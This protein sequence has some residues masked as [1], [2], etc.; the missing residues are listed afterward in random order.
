MVG[1]HLPCLV[2]PVE[3]VG[4]HLHHDQNAMKNP[5]QEK[6]NTRPYML[7]TFRMG[8]ERALWLIGLTSGASHSSETLT[9]L[10]KPQLAAC[11]REFS[12]GLLGRKIFPLR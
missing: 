8:T 12:L 2:K 3:N 4:V 6:K 9:M 5:N 10:T 1:R 7:M 11:A